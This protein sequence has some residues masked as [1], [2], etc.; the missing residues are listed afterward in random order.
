[1]EGL[2]HSKSLFHSQIQDNKGDKILNDIRIWLSVNIGP[3]GSV[4]LLD[5]PGL[6][7]LHF[8]ANFTEWIIDSI[9]DLINL[10]ALL[11]SS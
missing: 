9:G 3:D 11:A 4:C 2:G 5:R 7:K 10:F 1:M 6:L 8:S